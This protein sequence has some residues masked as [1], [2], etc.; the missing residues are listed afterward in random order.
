MVQDAKVAVGEVTLKNVRLSF[1]D[2]L[3]VG[4]TGDARKKGKNAG[5]VPWRNNANF[6]IPKSTEEGKKLYAACRSAMSD[7]KTSLW[8]DPDTAPKIK[9]D[10]LALRD[11]DEEDWAGYAG[12]WYVS[13]SRTTYSKDANT[14]PKRPFR[15]IGPRKVKMDD[16]SMRF[17][18][19]KEGDSGA[20]YA[21]CYVNS[22]VRFWAQDD[23][24]YGKRINC[25]IEAVQFAR[26]GEAFGGGKRVNV[27]DEFDDQA[28]D[29]DGDLSTSKKPALAD[30]DDL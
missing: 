5:K 6:L 7:A 28:D 10:K 26:D 1:S 30:L 12:H 11:G 8:K 2:T 24:D 19:V 27:D 17:P 9:S 20:P 3:F 14:A 18:D 29:L 22:I 13:A 21:G 25:S 15:I 23:D 4:E 16:G